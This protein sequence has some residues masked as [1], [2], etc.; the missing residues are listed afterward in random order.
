MFKYV[1]QKHKVTISKIDLE[2]KPLNRV[3]TPKPF[4]LFRSGDAEQRN[5]KQFSRSQRRN[6]G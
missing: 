3:H 2:Y 6:E 4:L 1:Y 5:R